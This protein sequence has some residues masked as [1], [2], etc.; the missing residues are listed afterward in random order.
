MGIVERLFRLVRATINHQLDRAEDPES[1]LAQVIRGLES[2]VQAARVQ[3]RNMIAQEMELK[4]ELTAARNAATAWAGRAEAAVAAGR[5]DLARLALRRKRD[6]EEVALVYARQ[7]EEQRAALVRLRERA[8]RIQAQYES[9]RSRSHV[10]IAR[11]RRAK[12]TEALAKRFS[13]PM[14]AA[15]MER[16]RRKIR[17]SEASAAAS[18][19]IAASSVSA[20]Y[21]ERDDPDLDRELEAIKARVARFVAEFEPAVP[22]DSD[23]DDLGALDERRKTNALPSGL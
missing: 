17:S 12:A 19:E 10:L 23:H 6:S 14:A 21:L 4:A 2:D 8:R 16:A 9:A 22:A 11:N 3:T 13:S 20:G 5:D 7:L 1:L 18:D 15:E